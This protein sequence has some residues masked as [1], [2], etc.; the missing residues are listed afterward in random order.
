MKVSNGKLIEEYGK[1]NSARKVA[2]KLNMSSSTVSHRLKKLGVLRKWKKEINIDK[3]ISSYKNHQSIRK[4]AEELKISPETARYNLKQLGVLNKPIR[5][6][7]NDNY[8]SEDNMESF[9]WAGFIAA[10]GCIKFKNKKYK[11][12]SI[13]L[14]QKDHDHLKK[15]KQSI[16]F[17]GPIHKISSGRIDKSEMTIS[18]DKIFDDLVRFNIVPRKSLIYTFPKWLKKHE[19]VNHF[20]RGYFDGD[21]SFY[22]SLGKGKKIPQLY[23]SLRGTKEFLTEYKNILEINCNIKKNINKPRYNCGI[24][25]L[26]YGG[27]LSAKSIADF[28]Y[29]D[30]KQNTRLERKYNI[31]RSKNG[32]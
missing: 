32:I 2:Q 1:L 19:L 18:S 13:D 10:D 15:L 3:L 20:M 29:K 28:I 21:G 11:Q 23:F 7:W 14:S 16:V 12:L 22:T 8:F 30:S 4:V 25:I 26:E 6:S 9:Y 31:V 5:Y 24:H 17:D 27:N